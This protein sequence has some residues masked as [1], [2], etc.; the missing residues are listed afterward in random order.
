MMEINNAQT[1]GSGGSNTFT[2]GSAMRGGASG[3]PWIQDFGLGPSSDPPVSLGQN[4]LIG[5]TSYGATATEPKYLGA[6]N[7]DG[8][9]LDVLNRACGSNP[10]NC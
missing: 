10:G 5:V 1:F 8:R 3:G 2:Y 7:L 4:S 9:F 6:S